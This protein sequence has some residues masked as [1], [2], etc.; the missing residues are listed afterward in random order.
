MLTLCGVALLTLHAP[1]AEKDTLNSDD[2][3]FVKEAA[4]DNMAKVMIA[5]LGVK[6]ATNSGV[7]TFAEMI[8]KDHAL[9]SEELKKLAATKGVDL[10]VGI[11]PKQAE[12]IQELEKVSGAEFDKNFLAEMVSDH[13]NNVSDFEEAS[14]NSKDADLKSWVNK[15][16]PTL[17]THLDRANQLNG[18]ASAAPNNANNTARNVRDRNDKTLTPLDQ[19][20]SKSDT[21]I[22]AQIRRGIMAEKD[23]ST[24][25]Q[26][27]KIITTNG[28]VTLRGPVNNAE[29][30][31][32]IGKIAERTVPAINV[33][34]QLEVK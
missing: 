15:M 34:S 16:I 29:E 10:S 2:V 21:E 30:K 11:E 32:L 17:K 31:L 25:A 26:N 4:A 27:V 13:K 14:T 22:T 20:S 19:G 8:V 5:E 23:I 12:R 24:N 3:T 33:D 28:K 7:K 9:A 1:A 18:D 6:K